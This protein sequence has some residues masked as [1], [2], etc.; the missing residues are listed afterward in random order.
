[1]RRII[2]RHVQ[3]CKNRSQR[4]TEPTQGRSDAV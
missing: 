1:M 2:L 3:P 4:Q